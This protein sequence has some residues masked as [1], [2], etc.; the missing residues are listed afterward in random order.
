MPFVNVNE[1]GGGLTPLD[2]DTVPIKWFAI[3]RR[4]K[5]TAAD[6]RSKHGLPV[7]PAT[8]G[9]GQLAIVIATSG[10]AVGDALRTVF[11]ADVVAHRVDTEANI[12]A[13]VAIL[14]AAGKLQRTLHTTTQGVNP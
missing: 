7:D 2:V 3:Q 4:V 6:A 8:I 12:N 5:G 9:A 10:G 14:L 13:D 11:L 1:D